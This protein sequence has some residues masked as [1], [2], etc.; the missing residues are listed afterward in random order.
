MSGTTM[1]SAMEARPSGSVMWS[2]TEQGI[3]TCKEAGGLKINEKLSRDQKGRVV[4]IV[5]HLL[6]EDV[7]R[8]DAVEQAEQPQRA[9]H[10]LVEQGETSI[11]RFLPL[12]GPRRPRP[13][14]L[15]LLAPLPGQAAAHQAHLTRQAGLV[16]GPGLL[17]PPGTG[18]QG[19]PGEGDQGP[20]QHRPGQPPPEAV[21]HAE[22]DIRTRSVC[23]TSHE[24]LLTLLCILFDNNHLWL[25]DF[26]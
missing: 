10:P 15:A 18:Q 24:T 8:E 12:A 11:E 19:E 4:C 22:R 16:G 6:A 3:L 7:G 1:A 2:L 9:Q 5:Q 17:Q 20:G 13:G 23:Q 25:L 26:K 21:E 14:P